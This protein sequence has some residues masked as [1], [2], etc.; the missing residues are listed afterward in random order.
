MRIERK[1]ATVIAISVNTHKQ[2]RAFSL[3]WQFRGAAGRFENLTPGELIGRVQ[4][5]LKFVYLG[6]GAAVASY[7]G[8]SS[9]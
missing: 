4:V 8:E 7:L 9:R 6:I 1:S 5:A 2:L 3:C